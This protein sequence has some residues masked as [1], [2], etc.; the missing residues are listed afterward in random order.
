VGCDLLWWQGP[1]HPR[2]APL[3]LVHLSSHS[4][5]RKKPIRYNTG[6]MKKER[7]PKVE[8]DLDLVK[9]YAETFIPRFD[10]YPMQMADGS[11]IC[12]KK[13]LDLAYVSLHLQGNPTLGAYALDVHGR[14]KWICLD[15]D[16]E[17]QW[18]QVVAA[19][20]DL[21]QQGVKAYLEPSR[22]G[23]HLWLFTRPLPGAD[24]RRVGR[25]LIAH[26]ELGS[27]EVFPKQDRL[28]TGPGSF[29]RLPLGKHRKTGRRY[30]F[31]T[32]TGKPLAPT[33][34][35]QI[36][37][38]GT[39]VVIPDSFISQALDATVPQPPVVPTPSFSAP[40]EPVT[41]ATPAER[42]KQAISVRE[43][44]GQYVELDPQ[45]RGHCPFHDDQHQ[46]F[47]VNEESNYWHCWAG[48][49]GGSIIDFWMKWREKQGEDPSFV[50]AITDLTNMLL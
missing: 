41:G 5:T 18:Q 1:L 10:L 9:A 35:R 49:G 31:T 29:V 47:G 17:H 32:P 34:R 37:L 48:C 6:R 16:D 45:G 27:I 7:P 20:T 30:H 25:Y 8:L 15:A 43:F 24:A 3:V 11:Y 19:A 39:P 12:V 36:Q 50:A 4:Q 26:Y 44:V 38:M 42:I 22:R 13:P 21:H 33:I 28:V 14:A 40:D 2:V 23:G 46:S